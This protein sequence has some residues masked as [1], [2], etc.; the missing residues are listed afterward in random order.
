MFIE[1][2]F[3]KLTGRLFG[4]VA[5]DLESKISV[6]EKKLL[7][8]NTAKQY[9][10]VKTMVDHEIQNSLTFEK[11]HHASGS[12]TLLR[13]HWALEFILEFMQE[14]GRCSDH[15]KTSDIATEVYNRTLSHHHPWITRKL[16]GLAMY[17]LPSRKDLVVAMCKQDYDHVI[18][19]LNKVVHSGKKVYIAIQIILEDNDL[20]DIP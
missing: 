2:R 3:F 20:L 7:D 13:L 16:A 12:R 10:T 1:C 5:K 17:L 9:T 15:D 8:D 18:E 6:I 19:L 14:L 11:G 4:F